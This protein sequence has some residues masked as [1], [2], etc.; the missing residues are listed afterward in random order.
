MMVK[1]KEAANAGKNN[2]LQRRESQTEPQ[3][4]PT[5]KEKEEELAKPTTKE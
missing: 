1:T 4:V 5:L 2:S 3:K